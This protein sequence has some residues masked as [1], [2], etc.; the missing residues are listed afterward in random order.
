M[1]G[2]CVNGCFLWWLQTQL[3]IPDT[4][5][6]KLHWFLTSLTWSWFSSFAHV[7][8]VTGVS[9]SWFHNA[10]NQGGESVDTLGWRSGPRDACNWSA[11][12][13]SAGMNV[14]KCTTV[15]VTCLT[16]NVWKMVLVNQD[17][18]MPELQTRSQSRADAIEKSGKSFLEAYKS[19]NA[20]SARR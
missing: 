20:M 13:S 4:T 2:S 10:E 9:C 18:A 16:K 5:M 3:Q 8:P 12:I 14:I 6:L 19:L 15:L 7:F 1:P 11:P 17:V